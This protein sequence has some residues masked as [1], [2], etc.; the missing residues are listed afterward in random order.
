[1]ANVIKKWYNTP[2]NKTWYHNDELVHKAVEKGNIT[3]EDY[4]M[5][6]GKDYE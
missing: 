2:S 3:P 1:M 5:I 4:K 6:T